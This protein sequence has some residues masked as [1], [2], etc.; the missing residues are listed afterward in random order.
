[1]PGKEKSI[2]RRRI[3]SAYFS[4]VVS[5][6]LVLLLVGAASLLLVNTKRVSDYFREHMNISVLLRPEVTDAESVLVGE[7]IGKLPFVLGTEYVSRDQGEKEMAE[8]LGED[9]LS[10]F[11]S[12][13]VPISYNVT[14]KPEYVVAD[15]VKVAEKALGGMAEVEEVVWQQSLVD[16][17]NENL[18]KITLAF[19]VAIAL[20]LFI[21]FVL[22]SNT[23]RLSVYDKR[24]SVHTMK[25]VGATRGFIRAPFLTRAAFL[26][27]VSALLAVI[28][29]VALLYLLRE[30]FAQLFAVFSLDSLLL[31][32]GIVVLSG[33]VICVASTW[34]VVD[35]LVT[36]GKDELYY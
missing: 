34:L 10:V 19:G 14:L 18:R 29:L 21:S 31:V 12:S 15:S 4:S 7:K 24:F 36:M 32:V 27:L 1:M 23:M 17:L 25:L 6:S 22:I 33:L 5:I 8:M 20:L 30:E 26:G 35:K 11:E 9:F 2:V 3:R 28:M 13:P 16:T